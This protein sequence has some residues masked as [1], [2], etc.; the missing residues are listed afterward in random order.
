[1]TKY[2]KQRIELFGDKAFAPLTVDDTLKDDISA[3]ELGF[4]TLLP[5]RDHGGRGL[6]YV[7][8]CRLGNGGYD[9]MSMVGTMLQAF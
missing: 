8:P 2:W 4:L 1:L 9:Y 7:E 5:G 3:L 6:V